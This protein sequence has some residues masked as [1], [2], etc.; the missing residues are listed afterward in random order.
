M[1]KTSVYRAGFAGGLVLLLTAGFAGCTSS[2]QKKID[3]ALPRQEQ[4]QLLVNPNFFEVAGLDGE[5]MTNYWYSIPGLT[6]GRHTVDFYQ[7]SITATTVASGP[8][9]STTVK[10]GNMTVT[11]TSQ[12]TQSYASFR[13]SSGLLSLAHEYEA[14][15]ACLLTNDAEGKP[16]ILPAGYTEWYWEW[17]KASKKA[18]ESL[19]TIKDGHHLFADGAWLFMVFIDGELYTYFDMGQKKEIIL[20]KG[21]H[22]LSIVDKK[23][24]LAET[25]SFSVELNIQDDEVDL[26]ITGSKQV[27]SVQSAAAA[28]LVSGAD[29]GVPAAAGE[30]VLEVHIVKRSSLAAEILLD[31]TPLVSSKEREAVQRF[32]IPNGAHTITGKLF[33]YPSAAKTFTANSNLIVATFK[34]GAFTNSL[35]IEE[36]AAEE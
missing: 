29:P 6:P 18:G 21:S 4:A 10:S 17:R 12:P 34:Q 22:T 14:G 25:V 13:R 26:E 32:K 1:K 36:R 15:K 19:L 20:S 28:P 24:P 27:F 23:D 33:S 11:S 7:G 2:A 31:G 5:K 16:L 8:A 3:A 9:T 35:E 30:S